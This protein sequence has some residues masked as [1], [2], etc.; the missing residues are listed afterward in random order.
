MQNKIRNR[1]SARGSEVLSIYFTAGYPELGDTIEILQALEKSGVDFVEVGMPF[2]DPLADGPVIQ[3]TSSQA[4]ENGM[5][6]QLLFDQIEQAGL[7]SLPCVWMGY[8]NQVMQFGIEAFLEQCKRVGIDTL[9]IPDLP[10]EIYKR[11]FEVLFQKYNVSLVFLIS[12]QTSEA[13]IRKI[14]AL[15]KAFIYV[16]SDASITGA[17]KDI[18]AGQEAYFQRIKDME[19]DNPCVIG[20][21]IRDH[22]SFTT[23]CKYAEGAIIG[24]AFLKHIAES[25]SLEEDIISFVNAIRDIV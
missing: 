11:D 10:A 5:H 24:S 3:E 9:I 2:S 8:L 21:G 20:F 19:L 14:D 25:K 22:A 7:V 16:V 4:L 23:A 6:M 1:I 18:S 17:Q 13:R 15:S 12:P